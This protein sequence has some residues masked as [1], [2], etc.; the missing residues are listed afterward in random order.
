MKLLILFLLSTIANATTPDFSNTPLMP[1]Y[2]PS[3]AFLSTNMSLHMGKTEI[4]FKEN[5]VITWNGRRITKDKQLVKAFKQLVNPEE[6]REFCKVD[7]E[8]LTISGTVTMN[9]DSLCFSNGKIK[10]AKNGMCEPVKINDMG[11]TTTQETPG[12]ICTLGCINSHLNPKT[13]SCE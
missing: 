11:N 5:G 7:T 6:R 2:I 8:N 12:A 3:T 1:G 10:K 13:C 9:E 4:E